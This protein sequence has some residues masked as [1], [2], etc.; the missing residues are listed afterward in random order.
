[1]TRTFLSILA[2]FIFITGCKNSNSSL[3][4][5]I[6]APGEMPNITRDNA[7]NIHLVYGKGDSLL[8]CY[9][10]DRGVTF[11][12][13]ALISILPN[14]TAA[15]MRGPQ[16]AA[17]SDGLSVTA[18]NAAGDIFSFVKNNSGEWM[19][20][21]RVNDRDTVAKENF[22]ALAA[23]GQ[24]AFAVWLD[25]RDRHN[26][27]F[28]SKSSDGGRTWSKNMMVYASVDSTVCECC[29]PSVVMRGNNIYVMFRNWL[30]GNRD[31]Y[32][33]RSSDGGSTF[34]KPE[35]LG[36]GSW[37]LNGC[38]M[39]GG[40]LVINKEGQP[41]TVWNRKGTI[42]SCEPG[43]EESKVGEGRSGTLESLNGRNVYAWEA[44]SAI[45]ISMPE[46]EKKELGKG[47]LPI[48]KAVGDDQI[49][50]IWENDKKIH[51]AIMSL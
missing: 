1:M 34:G 38:P 14:L 50:C 18:C 12:S 43:K 16:I 48:I 37:A 45:M 17:T 7:N 27:I 25:L 46:K 21:A 32:L 23:D 15:H 36:T 9:S 35:K 39:D 11:S 2:A 33:I 47:Q 8:Y 30:D 41:V 6:I 44:K 40:T 20:T 5:S 29:K 4:D 13:P 22:M 42:F 49:I 28:S 3:A 10:A 26:K 31:L 19:K 24:N 51:R